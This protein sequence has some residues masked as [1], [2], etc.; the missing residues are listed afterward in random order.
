MDG[1]TRM[2]VGKA[3]ESGTLRFRSE[4][5]ALMGFHELRVRGWSQLPWK[6]RLRIN[7]A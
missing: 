2:D 5:T 1:M 7:S 4:M 6:A 3:S